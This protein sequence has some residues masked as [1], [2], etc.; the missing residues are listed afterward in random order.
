M[1]EMRDERNEEENGVM[2]SEAESCLRGG[3]MEGCQGT[4]IRSNG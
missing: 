1:S 4:C 3:V 2:L